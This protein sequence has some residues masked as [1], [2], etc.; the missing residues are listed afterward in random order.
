MRDQGPF[1]PVGLLRWLRRVPVRSG[2]QFAVAAALTL[3]ANDFGVCW[4]SIR[5][6]AN[7]TRLSRPTV[8]RALAGL[9]AAGVIERRARHAPNG[10]RTSD[11][12]SLVGGQTPVSE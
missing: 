1:S 2:P 11:Q 3:H 12:I 5:S 9:E 6:L 4:P 10:A 7:V 8:Q